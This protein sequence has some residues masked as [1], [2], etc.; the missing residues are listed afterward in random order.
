MNFGSPVAKILEAK[1]NGDLVVVGSN[2]GTLGL[3]SRVS[4]ALTF[5]D[6]MRGISLVNLSAS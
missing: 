3:K 4:E 2:V 6:P 1:S 5:F